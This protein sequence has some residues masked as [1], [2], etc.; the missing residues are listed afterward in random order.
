[1][2][3]HLK[4]IRPKVNY[5]KER[6]LKERNKLSGGTFEK[7]FL[8]KRCFVTGGVILGFMKQTPLTA[9]GG[10]GGRVVP[11]QNNSS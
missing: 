4:L 6:N 3:C 2:K 1:M 5:R 11:L 10:G 7:V 9:H 8:H